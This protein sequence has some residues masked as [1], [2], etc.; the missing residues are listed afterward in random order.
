MPLHFL[1]QA[2]G[3]LLDAETLTQT[4]K[5]MNTWNRRGDGSTCPALV[6][7]GQMAHSSGQ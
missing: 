2:N 6:F 1:P 4:V 3:V 5:Q 7:Q